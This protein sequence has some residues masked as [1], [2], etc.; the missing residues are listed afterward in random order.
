MI[1]GVGLPTS[2]TPEYLF[3]RGIRGGILVSLKTKLKQRKPDHVDLV[4]CLDRP[5]A[6]EL[7]RARTE[8]RKQSDSRMVG[9]VTQAV[10]EL[11][12]KAADASVT[13]RLSS[14][15]W[16]EYNTLIGEHPPRD[17]HEEQ[18]NSS[19]FFMAAAKA[20]AVEVTGKSTVP[21]PDEDWDDFAAGLTDGEYDRLAGAVV[22][23]NRNLATVNIAP[24]A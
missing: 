10:K 1:S 20:T 23:V 12:K 4:F 13:I 8:A 22:Q 9:G 21:I 14:L 18:F 2:F 19:T 24:L 11:E 17:G 5:L 15:P 7:D 3:D 6:A 16:E